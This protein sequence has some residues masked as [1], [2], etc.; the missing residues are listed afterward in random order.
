MFAK[1]SVNE[2]LLSAIGNTSYGSC[3][4]AGVGAGRLPKAPR[5]THKEEKGDT[6][7]GPPEKGAPKRTRR[8][9]RSRYVVTLKTTQPG[10]Q[11][12]APPVTPRP[13]YRIVGWLS[14][15]SARAV[16]L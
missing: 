12:T 2:T 1:Y 14:R 8:N 10:K 6:K 3:L 7:K 4:G 9:G 16:G 15:I 13:L 5:P 11:S